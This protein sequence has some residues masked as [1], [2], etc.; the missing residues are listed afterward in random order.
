MYFGSS[1][2][3]S[4][5][6][7]VSLE[8]R[9][10][11]GSVHGCASAHLLPVHLPV[12]LRHMTA[13]QD[14]EKLVREERQGKSTHW[15][16]SSS[17]MRRTS[18]E[19][20][21]GSWPENSVFRRP[22]CGKYSR[23]R[24]SPTGRQQAMASPRPDQHYVH[25]AG[26]RSRASSNMLTGG[27]ISPAVEQIAPPVTDICPPPPPQSKAEIWLKLCSPETWHVM[28]SYLD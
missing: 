20:Q 15:R 2:R 23:K 13:S 3:N 21:Q 4:M 8:K 6:I 14:R 16:R 18:W 27:A 17:N 12:N 11:W 26:G 28:F 5:K 7:T 24:R 25:R 1:W 19:S 9:I 10:P 22:M